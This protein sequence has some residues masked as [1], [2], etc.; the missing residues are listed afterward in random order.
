MKLKK[1]IPALALCLALL[2]G[3][4]MFS[5]SANELP[6]IPPHEHTWDAGVVTTAPTCTAA[7]VMTFTCSCGAT[8]TESIPATGHTY[9]Y[10]DNGNGTHTVACTKCSYSATESHTYA[11]GVCVCGNR[12]TADLPRILSAHPHIDENVNLVYAAYVPDGYTNPYMVFTFLGNSY[13]VRGYT[14]DASGNLCFEF[15]NCFPQYMGDNIAAVLHTTHGG[16]DVTDR[17]DA[18]SIRQY[19]VNQLANNPSAKLR[20][21]LS[22]LL[23][24]GAAAQQ[25]VGYKT[26]ALVTDGLTLTPSSFTPLSG[27]SVTFSGTANAGTDWRSAT[28]VLRNTLAVRFYFRTD[29]VNGL[30]VRCTLNGRTTIFTDEDFCR[31]DGAQNVYYIDVEGIEAT[32][33]DQPVTAAFYRSGAQTGRSASYTV[34]TYV[35]SMQNCADAN[36]QRLVR[37][38]YNYGASASAYAA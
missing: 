11:N 8:K 21:L 23:T 2:L 22:D 17:V 29:N 38:L 20:T 1:R 13:T 15:T 30:Q 35:C 7:G 4:F 19:C 10:T 36:L 14:T 18:Y 24:Y 34:N 31:A 9:T 12:Q 25:Y 32:G 16:A 28:L 5:V 37:A 33:F 3:V 26:D 27:R 6:I